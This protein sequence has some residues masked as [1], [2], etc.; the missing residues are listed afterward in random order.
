MIFIRDIERCPY[1][2]KDPEY[3]EWSRKNDERLNAL[4]E[5]R[6]ELLMHAFQYLSHEDRVVRDMSKF[7]I[8][9]L[10]KG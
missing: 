1:V 5:A 9:I 6:K 7:V 4:R 10:D 3:E 2:P 8:W